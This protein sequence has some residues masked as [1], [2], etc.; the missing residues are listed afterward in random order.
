VRLSTKGRY[1]TRAMLDLAIHYGG[2]PVLLKDIA[3]RQEI[4]ERYLENIM[5]RLVSSG[6]ARS[7]RGQKGGFSLAKPPKE[8]RLSEVVQVLEGPIA[9]VECVDNP[10]LCN[11]SPD[12]VTIEIWGRLKKVM[13]DLLD[14]I[15]LQ[16]MV[17]MARKKVSKFRIRH[18]TP[19]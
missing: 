14:S 17:E 13:L 8:I 4:S 10:R 12:C 9:P 2:E 18:I 11:R 19:L 1:G 16:D 15:T 7:A 5:V 6:L 3:K